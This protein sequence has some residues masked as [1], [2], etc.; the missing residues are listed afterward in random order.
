MLLS[1]FSRLAPHPE[2]INASAALA[3]SANSLDEPCPACG[4]SVPFLTTDT[5]GA[6]CANGH[7]WGAYA[8]LPSS[9][10]MR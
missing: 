2:P 10:C 3:A 1:L 7:V 4:A 5:E 9:V 6:V 8:P